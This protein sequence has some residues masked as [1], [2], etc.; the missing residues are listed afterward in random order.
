MRV[1]NESDSFLPRSNTWTINASHATN[2]PL[3]YPKNK[4][5]EM[6]IAPTVCN[7]YEE[8]P[9]TR[10][11]WLQAFPCTREWCTDVANRRTA[12]FRSKGD[13]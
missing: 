1:S 4:R 10:D 8:N 6:R 11:D 12:K 13:A 9:F 2:N 7:I 3:M 5:N